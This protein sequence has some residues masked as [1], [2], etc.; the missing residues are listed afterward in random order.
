[1]LRHRTIAMRS[2]SSRA[3]AGFSSTVLTATKWNPALSSSSQRGSLI[4]LKTFRQISLRGC[5]SMVPPVVNDLVLDAGA[6]GRRG[7]LN[8][9]IHEGHEDPRR[10]RAQ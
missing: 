4:G 6:L 1:M 2:T 10:R 5:C 8:T 7:D 9:K 3:A